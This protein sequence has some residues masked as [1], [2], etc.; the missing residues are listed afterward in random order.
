MSRQRHRGRK[1][2]D[3]RDNA[4]TEVSFK[5][6]PTAAVSPSRSRQSSPRRSPQKRSRTAVVDED[7]PGPVQRGGRKRQRQT[8]RDRRQTQVPVS[9]VVKVFH[10]VV[11]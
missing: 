3:T 6:E 7:G 8:S 4:D 1:S 5:T 10:L 2:D 9:A 11:C